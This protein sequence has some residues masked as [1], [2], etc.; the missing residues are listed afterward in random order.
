MSEVSSD[1]QNEISRESALV[2]EQLHNISRISERTNRSLADVIGTTIVE[3]KDC[4]GIS[5][6]QIRLKVD[7]IL[8]EDKNDPLLFAES[9]YTWD[10]KDHQVTLDKGYIRGVITAISEAPASLTS[11]LLLD[12]VRERVAHEYYHARQQEKY[13]KSAARS[14]E[15]AQKGGGQYFRDRGE[16]AANIFALNYV[17]N[18]KDKNLLG[19][20]AT[21]IN[22]FHRVPEIRKRLAK[23]I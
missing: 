3:V 10:G 7:N 9:V 20:V 1:L 21:L 23:S 6:L 13:P 15:A 16:L 22:N 8:Y 11:E 14:H 5:D 2:Y 17:K 19:R 12:N 18:R 4:A